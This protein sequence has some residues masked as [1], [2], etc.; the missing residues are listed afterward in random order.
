M[1]LV[2]DFRNKHKKQ[3]SQKENA[4][5]LRAQVQPATT[6]LMQWLLRLLEDSIRQEFIRVVCDEIR[7]SDAF[8]QDDY[9]SERITI[10]GVEKTGKTIVIKPT[11]VTGRLEMSETGKPP[12]YLLIWTPQ[13]GLSA[14]EQWCIAPVI[15]GGEFGER[16]VLSKDSCEKALSDLFELRP[17]VY[18]LSELAIE[19]TE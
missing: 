17:V 13:P 5:N 8:L 10:Q 2:D 19:P 12:R 16:E 18:D 14:A 11:S 7:V 6:N 1:S 15:A 9:Q 3:Q 4:R